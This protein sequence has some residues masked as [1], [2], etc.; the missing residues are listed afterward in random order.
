MFFP[1]Q[2]TPQSIIP[3]EVSVKITKV[4]KLEKQFSLTLFNFMVMVMLLRQKKDKSEKI[5][6][7]TLMFREV[8]VDEMPKI[9]SRN[10]GE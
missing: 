1:T 8:S 5:L 10:V 3:Y 7:T 9:I 4:L 2:E 6:M